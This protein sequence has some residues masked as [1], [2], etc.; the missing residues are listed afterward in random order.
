M[1][2]FMGFRRNPIVVG[3]AGLLVI[4]IGV[5]KGVI[6]AIALGVLVIGLA[7]FRFLFGAR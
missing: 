1:M 7:A 4:A 3:L 6:L 2:Q 5:I